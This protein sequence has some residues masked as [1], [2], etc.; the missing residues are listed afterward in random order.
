[1]LAAVVRGRNREESMNIPTA[2]RE[3]FQSL[4]SKKD[5][6][7]TG[8]KEH[9]S[10]ATAPSENAELEAHAEGREDIG[11]SGMVSPNEEFRRAVLDVDIERIR[12]AL[13]KGADVN[14]RFDVFGTALHR[15]PFDAV[16]KPRKLA[17]IKLLIERGADLE[18][19]DQNDYTPLKEAVNARF[20]GATAML[21]RAGAK[22]HEAI[23]TDLMYNGQH[24]WGKGPL[25]LELLRHM[26]PRTIDVDSYIR[27]DDADEAAVSTRSQVEISSIRVSSDPLGRAI[28]KALEH[29]QQAHAN[30]DFHYS[31]LAALDED[32]LAETR[33]TFMSVRQSGGVVLE[34]EDGM[35]RSN[36]L[37]QLKDAGLIEN[38]GYKTFRLTPEGRETTVDF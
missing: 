31:D 19:T 25:L 14:L 38:S 26:S 2:I 3:L 7:K 27:R 5:R 33:R 32:Y 15:L 12:T 36:I 16:S 13:D 35:A 37:K 1:M 22:P 24:T 20:V 17:I 28:K 10:D 21:L 34:S 6:I 23:A 11:T 29:L 8:P 4:A 18:A 9:E 30:S